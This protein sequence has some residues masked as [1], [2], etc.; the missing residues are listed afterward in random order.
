MSVFKEIY[1]FYGTIAI[2][3]VLPY[4]PVRNK[5]K[6]LLPT[7]RHSLFLVKI[8]IFV[9]FLS[10]IRQLPPSTLQ[11]KS[12]SKEKTQSR[13]HNFL[14]ISLPEKK[15]QLLSKIVLLSGQMKSATVLISADLLLWHL[16]SQQ[17]SIGFYESWELMTLKA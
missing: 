6:I 11:E 3:K 2:W 7:T 17:N 9:T 8:L 5:F 4:N 1:N 12:S 15:R 10:L 16:L 13:Q 14:A